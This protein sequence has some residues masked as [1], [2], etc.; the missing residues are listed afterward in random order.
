[1]REKKN[2]TAQIDY[3]VQLGET[4]VPLEVKSGKQG[5][6]QSMWIFMKEKKSNY[7]IR[8]SLENFCKY[9]NINVYPLYSIGNILTERN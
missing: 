9:Q 7:G 1:V 3:V 8:T 4:I 6:M 5:K 2:A